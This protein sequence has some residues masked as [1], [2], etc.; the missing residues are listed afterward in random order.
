MSTQKEK[1]GAHHPASQNF[2]TIDDTTKA[3]SVSP[4]DFIKSVA[5]AAKGSAK[6][7]AAHWIPDG[8]LVGREWISTQHSSLKVNVRT[9]LWKHWSQ[10]GRGGDLVNLVAERDNVQPLEAAKR[11]AK[12]LGLPEFRGEKGESVRSPKKSGSRTKHRQTRKDASCEMGAQESLRIVIP[13]PK[14]A[15]PQPQHSYESDRYVYCDERG[16][17]RFYN[18]RSNYFRKGKKAFK[19]FCQQSLWRKE[20]GELI[21]QWKA[22]PAPWTLFGL[23]KLALNPTSPVLVVEGEKSAKHAARLFPDWVV[24][25]TLC[26]SDSP[27]KSDWS[28]LNSRDVVIWADNDEPGRTYRQKVARLCTA[29]GAKR[30]R[31]LNLAAL[32]AMKDLTDLTEGFDAADAL[33]AGWT[34]AA[35]AAEGERLFEDVNVEEETNQCDT[36]APSQR[37]KFVLTDDG[38]SA[39]IEKDDDSRLVPICSWL[40]PVAHAR[41]DEGKNWSCLVRLRDREGVEKDCQLKAEW[42]SGIEEVLRPLLNHG[43]VLAQRGPAKRLLIEYIQSAPSLPLYRCVPKTGWYKGVFVLPEE[44]IGKPQ[45]DER[46]VFQSELMP[47]QSVLDV[48]NT[49]EDWKAN[50]SRYCAGNSRLVMAVSAALAAPLLELIGQESGGF[51]F[52]GS[53]SVGKTTAL[54]VACSVLGRHDYMK[55]WRATS[56]GLEATAVAHNDLLLVLDEMGQ[57]N[58]DVGETAYL[59]ANGRG[60]Q[61]MNKSTSG[62]PCFTFRLLFISSGEAG[63]HELAQNG[64]RVTG[65]QELRIADIPADAGAG[66]GL[67]ENLHGMRSGK[68]FADYLRNATANTYGAIFRQFVHKLTEDRHRAAEDIAELKRMFVLEHASHL[69]VSEQVGRVVERF[70][71]LAAAGELATAWGLTGWQPGEAPRAAAKCLMDWIDSRGGTGTQETAALL[72]KVRLFFEQ[73]GESRFTLVGAN[74]DKVNDDRQTI[75]R[76]GFKSMAADG[77]G[78]EYFVFP[79]IFNKEICNGFDQRIAIKV[80]SEHRFIA[81]ASGKNSVSK[82][83]SDIGTTKRFYHFTSKLFT[84]D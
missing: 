28:P 12:F 11:L 20:D 22:P 36:G 63:L 17:N 27:E 10:S 23:E 18:I 52:R 13:I 38:V 39:Y 8:K 21:W 80:L 83:F 64:R 84:D 60:K 19:E 16:N 55:T 72:A 40:Q 15:P 82:Y 2:V 70:A 62:R 48:Q 50:V 9:G 79:E 69:E 65:G 49:V 37:N 44:T 53:S 77:S 1:A 58:C 68:E 74:G 25:S 7:V 31:Q 3:H 33:K 29:I 14:N 32:A 26:G 57:A 59:L 41:D 54:L 76:V 5:A 51:H 66:H 47:S 67:F 43:L 78:F 4:S 61:R 34:A 35:I 42:F 46:V 81:G 6:D 56:N 24:V 73:H 71:L 75:N 45:T 30:V